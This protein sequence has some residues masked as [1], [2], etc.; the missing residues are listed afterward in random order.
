MWER[1]FYGYMRPKWSFLANPQSTASGVK[2][3]TDNAAR[4]TILVMR[5]GSGN[6]MMWGYFSSA[7]TG[8]L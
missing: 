7:G 1:G 6:I 2:S 5:Y 8:K 4:S 3:N